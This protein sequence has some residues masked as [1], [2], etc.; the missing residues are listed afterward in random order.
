MHPKNH[1]TS[2]INPA[3]KECAFGDMGVDLETM[4]RII[5]RVAGMVLVA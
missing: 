2:R 5:D 3:S 4:I 1:L